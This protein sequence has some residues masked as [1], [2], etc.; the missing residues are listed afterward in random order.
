MDPPDAEGSGRRDK[1][2]LLH[3]L[4]TSGLNSLWVGRDG[5]GDMTLPLTTHRST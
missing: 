3:A 2:A 1:N 5:N 4:T